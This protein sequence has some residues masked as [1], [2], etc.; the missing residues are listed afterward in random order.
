LA[1]TD[2]AGSSLTPATA[3]PLA[4][5]KYNLSMP[6]DLDKKESAVF[7]MR[8]TIVQEQKIDNF[9]MDTCSK[10][11]EIL[12]TELNKNFMTELAMVTVAEPLAASDDIGTD[13]D[14]YHGI[15]FIFVGGS[16]AAR[17]AAAADI[18][19]WET[20]NLSVP[21]F[22]V[23]PDSIENAAILLQEAVE[24]DDGMRKIV[25][26]QF[27]DNNCYFSCL[28]DGSKSLPTRDQTDNKYHIPGRMAVA[29]HGVIKNLINMSVP[30]LRGA[31]DCEKVVVTPLPRYL[32]KCCNNKE[33]LLNRKEP[34][35]KQMLEDSLAEVKKSTQELI[36]G[37]KIRSFCVLSPLELLSDR[38]EDKEDIRF[39]DTD[40]VHLTPEGYNELAAAIDAAAMTGGSGMRNRT[41]LRHRHG[42]RPNYTSGR[43][44]SLQ[45]T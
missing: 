19:G 18:A 45:M 37:K 10:L 40:P 1:P 16:H 36:H 12:V 2:S 14:T 43:S 42:Y 13:T 4:A 20:K 15:K 35:F 34:V 33:H 7:E 26:F 38:N 29:D 41:L 6:A 23:N 44:G 31:G 21:G 25:I 9:N 32:K 8:H 17:L 24:E 28:D 22:R 5:V 27:M 11:I 30:L 3:S 39:W